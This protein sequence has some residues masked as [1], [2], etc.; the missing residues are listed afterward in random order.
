MS[1]LNSVPKPHVANKS[2]IAD[3]AEI[4]CLRRS[5]GSVSSMDIVRILLRESGSL[6]DDTV[7]QIVEDAFGELGNRAQNCGAG[8]RY[9]YE[10]RANDALLVKR[11]PE[12]IE[13]EPDLLYW[14]LLLSTRMNMKASRN[15]GGVDATA[16]FEH[17]CREV[18]IRFMGGPGP[19]VEAIVFGTGRHTED[20]SDHEEIDKGVFESAVRSLCKSLGEGIGF[21]ANVESRVF[22]R[23]GKLDIVVWRRFSDRRAGQ[24]IGFGQC[25]TGKYWKNDLTKL[26]PEGFCAKWMQKRPAVP[27]VRLYFVADRVIDGWYDQCVDGGIFFDR[28]RIV[29]QAT[30]LPGD[31]VRKINKWVTAAAASEGLMLP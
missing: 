18:A 15:H 17:L 23:D 11:D 20:L 12:V 1:D 27:P 4:E 6:N 13:E 28:C 22:A 8:N 2:I 3:F 31:L 5:D 14:Y 30:G 29:D 7:R 19:L 16:L 21:S 10:L 24:L 9:P 26:Q 25:K